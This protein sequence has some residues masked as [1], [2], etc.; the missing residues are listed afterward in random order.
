M[1]GPELPLERSIPRIEVPVHLFHGRHDQV[2]PGVCVV[3]WYDKLQAPEK[4]LVWFEDSA[5][6]PFLE[7]PARFREEML[8]VTA[9]GRSHRPAPFA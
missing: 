8:K 5:H 1:D 7:E 3:R 9:A 6:F 4:R 2:T